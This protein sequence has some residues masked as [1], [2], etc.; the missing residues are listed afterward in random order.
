MISVFDLFKI[1]IGPSSSHTMGPMKAAA[2]FMAALDER[3]RAGLSRLKVTL[4]GSL[5]WT[6]KGHRTDKAVMLGLSG[7]SPESIDPDDADRR[8]D[9]IATT[10][11]LVLADGTAIDFD[12]ARD[13]VFD[14]EEPAPVHPNT[15]RF[16]TFDRDG[17]ELKRETWFSLGGGFIRREGEADS[18]PP[19]ATA[20]PFDYRDAAELIE[21]CDRSR[22]SIAELVRANEAAFMDEAS[23]DGRLDRLTAVMFDCI[24]RGIRT[25][26]EL[27][28]GLRVKRRARALHARLL[29]SETRNLRQ[30][31]PAMDYASMYAIAVNEENAAGGR[32]VTAPTNGAAGVIPA[33]LRYYADHCQDASK[34]GIR[35]F[36]LTGAAIGALCKMNASISGA[37]VGCQ[38]EVGVACSMAAAGLTAALGGSSRQI[39]NAAEIGMEHHLGMTCDPIGGLVQ[40]PC[41][42]RNAFGAIKAINAASLALSGDG[43][44]HVTLDQVIRTMRDT[45]A[46]MQAKYK[47]TSRGGLAVNVPDC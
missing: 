19:S 10:R 39:E 11:Q 32:V 9:D 8:V 13:L 3:D 14:F 16:A 7:F 4:L 40:I 43:S 27:P 44:H 28:G 47:E 24:D 23:I 25:D 29:E 38:G 31:I 17:R 37:E 6:G 45:G 33:V 15:I 36:L 21:M 34:D 2:A 12:P 42:E 20:I 35:T 41:I 46:D 1:G 5:A 18:A 26:G 30:S 22:L